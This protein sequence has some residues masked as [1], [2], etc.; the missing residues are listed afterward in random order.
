MNKRTILIFD[1]AETSGGAFSRAVEMAALLTDYHYIFMTVKPFE[2]LYSGV[3]PSSYETIRLYTLINGVEEHQLTIYFQQILPK[4]LQPLADVPS[5]LI[6][7]LNKLFVNLQTAL[8]LYKR[9]I[10][11]VQS[12]N[13][14]HLTPYHIANKKKARLIYY[15]R[16][17]QYF[18]YLPNEIIDR[19]STYFFVGK[20][21]FEEYRKTLKVDES[22]C[23]VAHSPFNVD[24]RLAKENGDIDKQILNAKKN[25]RKII[26]CSSRICIEKGQH[27]LINAAQKTLKHYD[28]FHLFFIG[29]SSNSKRDLSYL[30]RIK[31]MV[32]D[33]GLGKHVSFLGHKNNPIHH[34]L[35]ADISVQAPTYFEALAGSLV[36]STQLGIITISSDIGGANEVIRENETGFL[37]KPEDSLQLSEIL[38]YCLANTDNLNHIRKQATLRSREKWNPEKI[39]LIIDNAYKG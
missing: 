4:F 14:I 21:L 18:S 9:N 10:S 22:R 26:I 38:T 13:G 39:K 36:E 19:A 3:V 5:R 2:T 1:P 29:E 35:H 8:R 34:L 25:G 31:T 33:F 17:L 27:V 30:K 16:D 15:F 24:S 20:N 23:V 37:F 11:V 12:N 32:S 28:N 6:A 7:K